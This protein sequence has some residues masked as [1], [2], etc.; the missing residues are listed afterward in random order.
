[1][2]CPLLLWANLPAWQLVQMFTALAVPPRMPVRNR[3]PCDD[4]SR[5]K[6]DEEAL[7]KVMAL[8]SVKWTPWQV[9]QI[10]LPFGSRMAEV[11]L[12]GLA[13]TGGRRYSVGLSFT[14]EVALV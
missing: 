12:A 6:V 9:V 5:P 14:L 3:Y 10:T 11:G 8:E 7:S 13:F 4:E 2:F 1:M